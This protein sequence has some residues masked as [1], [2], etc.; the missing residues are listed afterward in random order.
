MIGVSLRNSLR[1][2]EFF[3]EFEIVYA[4]RIQLHGARKH[5]Q[6]EKEE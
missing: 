4:A 2:A 1:T 6:K 5:Y 3:S